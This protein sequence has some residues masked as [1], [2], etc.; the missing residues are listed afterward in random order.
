MKFGGK[1]ERESKN[2]II[3]ASEKVRVSKER[4]E[5]VQ[6]CDLKIGRLVDI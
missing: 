1:Y 6:V 3:K 5:T 4:E 2:K